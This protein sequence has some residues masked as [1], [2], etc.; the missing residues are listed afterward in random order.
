[1]KEECQQDIMLP[2]N[3]I[4]TNLNKD[5][6]EKGIIPYLKFYLEQNNIKVKNNKFDFYIKEI[7]IPTKWEHNFLRK[8][9]A[10]P[11]FKVGSCSLN[12]NSTSFEWNE[13]M[14]EI[15]LSEEKEND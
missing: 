6:V 15:L 13:K 4:T 8:Q 2:F 11:W 12:E 5:K 3:V 9:M 10:K 14:K 1:M 7:E